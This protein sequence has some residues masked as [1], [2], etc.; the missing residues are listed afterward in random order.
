MDQLIED[1]QKASYIS[2]FGSYFSHSIA[3][4]IQGALFTT[5]KILLLKVT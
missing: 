3:Q 2:F 1:M 4:L 5:G